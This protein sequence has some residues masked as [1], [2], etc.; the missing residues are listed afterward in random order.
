MSLSGSW[1]QVLRNIGLGK[2]LE[3]TFYGSAK[4]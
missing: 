4:V 1:E 2:F 3:I